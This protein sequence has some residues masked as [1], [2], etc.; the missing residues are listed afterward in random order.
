M[1]FPPGSNGRNRERKDNRANGNRLFDTQNNAK[2]GYPWRGDPKVKNTDDGMIFATGS[3]VH[4]K[5]T[6]QHGCGANPTTHCTT[7]IQVGCDGT[8]KKDGTPYNADERAGISAGTL[9]GLRDGYPTGGVQT[10]AKGQND[11]DNNK[12]PQYLERIFQT[13]G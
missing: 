12:Q 10:Q 8:T 3:E 7:V 4:I 2:G 9:P 5:W 1:H 6:N 11:N 13:Q